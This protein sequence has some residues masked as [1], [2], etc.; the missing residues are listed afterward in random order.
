MKKEN[1]VFKQE[2]RLVG[3]IIPQPLADKLSL[4][5]LYSRQTRSKIIANLL[6]QQ[7]SQ[8][9][10]EEMIEE[11]A[12]QLSKK[13]EGLVTSKKAAFLSKARDQLKRKKV[14]SK[15]VNQILTITRRFHAED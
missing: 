15:H 5:C 4:Y 12:K 13:V 6:E 2:N 1:N 3:G 10:E 9:N 11:I 8:C 7:L 14:K